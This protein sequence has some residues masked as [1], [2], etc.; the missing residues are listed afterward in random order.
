E[1][2]LIATR[3]MHARCAEHE[4]ARLRRRARPRSG[5]LAPTRRGKLLRSGPASR[6]ASARCCAT[7]VLELWRR[8]P[9]SLTALGPSKGYVRLRA[10]RCET[11]TTLPR[12]LRFV[13]LLAVAA[14]AVPDDPIVVELGNAAISRTFAVD[15]DREVI[16]RSSPMVVEAWVEGGSIDGIPDAQRTT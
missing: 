15:R 1:A 12:L 3:T 5:R 16:V 14:C 4:R 9:G 8:A 13:S 10:A 6:A 2:T 11:A 7:L